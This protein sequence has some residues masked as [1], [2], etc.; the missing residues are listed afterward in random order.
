MKVRTAARLQQANCWQARA[1]IEKRLMSFARDTWVLTGRRGLSVYA[2]R[3]ACFGS[4]ALPPRRFTSFWRSAHETLISFAE[5]N[6]FASVFGN[7]KLRGNRATMM[8]FDEVN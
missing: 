7:K 8:I 3:L 2:S 4:G 6:S 5:F 1:R